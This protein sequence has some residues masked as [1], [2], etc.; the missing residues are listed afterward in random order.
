MVAYLEY[1]KFNLYEIFKVHHFLLDFLFADSI[2]QLRNY[3]QLG[4]LSDWEMKKQLQIAA[5]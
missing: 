1:L 5:A 4:I 3:E 2:K